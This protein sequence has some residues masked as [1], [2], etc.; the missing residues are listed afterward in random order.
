MKISGK[1]ISMRSIKTKI[2]L[3][4]LMCSLIS[5]VI[6]GSISIVESSRAVEENSR[7]K[8][9]LVC[10]NQSQQLDGMMEQVAQSV[11]TLN[12]LAV[13]DRKSVV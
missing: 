8:M 3:V 10:E 5:T 11:D 4:V 6:C 9:E 12:D 7:D 13:S 1:G 2:V